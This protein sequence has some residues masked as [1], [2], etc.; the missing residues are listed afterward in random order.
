MKIAFLIHRLSYS[1][2]PKM[3]A[4]VANQM[5]KRGH[6]V[7]IVTFFT[8]EQAHPLDPSVTVHS[9]N[10]SQS[11]NRIVRNTVEMAKTQ[12][13]L[14]R[15]LNRLEPDGVISFNISGTYVHLGLNQ[16]FGRYPVIF[17]ERADPNAYR[18]ATSKV[19]FAMMGCAAGTVFQTE[20]ARSFYAGKIYENS[21]VIPN[22]VIMK[23]K[24]AQ[25]LPEYLHTYA[26]RDNRIVTVGRLALQQKRQD[27]LLEGFRIVHEKHPE[28]KLVIYGDGGDKEQIQAIAE[29]KGLVDSVLLAGRVDWIEESICSAQAFALTSDF[30]GIPN[31]LIEA[32][33]VGVPCVSTDCSPGGAALLI[34]DGENGF[35]VPRGDAEAVAQKLLKLIEDPQISDRFA[36]EGPKVAETFSEDQIADLWEQYILKIF[37]KGK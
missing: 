29:E 31:A 37:K 25:S 20:G 3:L 15:L 1:G 6:D 14:I 11:G 10:I 36:E 23:P 4:W 34:R 18:G 27:I 26:E 24:V 28:M 8:G 22:P 35:L 30:E 12:Y 16:L 32:M 21:T 7:H 13:R 19:R 33:T 9:L 5:A 2:A 17:S